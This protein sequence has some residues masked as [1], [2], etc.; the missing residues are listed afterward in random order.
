VADASRVLP[1]TVLLAHLSRDHNRPEL[2]TATVQ[3]ESGPVGQRVPLQTAPALE[4][5]PVIVL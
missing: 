1:R 2:A 4:P 3:A 5:G